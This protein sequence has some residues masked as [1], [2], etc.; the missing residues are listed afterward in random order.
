MVD[1]AQENIWVDRLTRIGYFARGIIYGLIGLFALQLAVGLGGKI[2]D[3][4]GALSSLAGQPFGKILLIVV[5]VG[6]IGLFI[7]GIIRAVADPLR[8]GNDFKG[9]VS[10]AGYLIS[11]LSYG[12]LFIPTLNLIQGSGHRSAG[13]TATAQKAAAGVL[14]M[15]GGPLIVGVVG[16][17]L[18]GVGIYRIYAG[19]S[20]KLNERLKS[21]KMSAQQRRLANRLGRFGYIAIGIVF[22]ILGFLAILAAATLDPRKVG[23]FD[24]AL[25][26]L[27]RQSYGP[28]L[29]LIVALGLIAYAI[30]SFMGS[31]W[32]RIKEL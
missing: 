14:A 32:F 21:Y 9:L 18:I 13:S 20:S 3:Q 25:T 11:G 8:K 2:T 27:V 19:Y 5:A 23:G 29:L 10:R 17:A 24:Q 4:S 16:A 7:W 12:A 22:I 6:M 1:D 28:F 26:F 15:P 30:Y 31:L